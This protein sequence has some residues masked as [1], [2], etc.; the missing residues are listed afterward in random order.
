MPVA[1]LATLS[2]TVQIKNK[3]IVVVKQTRNA[4]EKREGCWLW[5]LFARLAK[6]NNMRHGDGDCMMDLFVEKAKTKKESGINLH[7]GR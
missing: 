2:N 5:G 4:A 3:K 6:K 1:Y 7:T